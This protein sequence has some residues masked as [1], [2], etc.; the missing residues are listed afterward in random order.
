MKISEKLKELRIFGLACIVFAGISCGGEK[1]TDDT[2]LQ[3]GAHGTSEAIVGED[4][5]LAKPRPAPI[6]ND[7]A[8]TEQQANQL[9]DTDENVDS[10]ARGLR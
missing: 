7:T 4:P 3:P 6:G 2:S 1:R 8:R 5:N 9:G 10:A